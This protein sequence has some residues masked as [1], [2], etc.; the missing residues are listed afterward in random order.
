MAANSSQSS[1]FVASESQD[2]TRQ[3]VDGKITKEQYAEAIRRDTLNLQRRIGVNP[4]GDKRS[5]HRA[6]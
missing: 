2:V 4:R 5:S 1:T 3:F 6:R